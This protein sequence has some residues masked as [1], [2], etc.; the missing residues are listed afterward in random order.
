MTIK[1][2]G[3][4]NVN[5]TDLEASSDFYRRNFGLDVLW[6]TEPPE[7]QDGAL[8]G[9]PGPVRWRGELLCDHRGR[10]GPVLDLLQWIQPATTVRAR[11]DGS[12]GFA[13]LVFSRPDAPADGTVMHDPDGT[14]IA[15]VRGDG[16]QPELAG[17]EIS[18]TSLTE[19][20]T[21]Y[22]DVLGLPVY[23]DGPL[24]TV[25]RATVRR[26]TVRL[27]GAR[28]TFRIILRAAEGAPLDSHRASDVGIHRV[29]IVVTEI[30]A[31]SLPPHSTGAHDVELGSGL[32]R[33]RAAFFT[34]PNGAVLEYV[35]DGLA[36]APAALYPDLHCDISTTNHDRGQFG[37]YLPIS[38]HDH[39]TAQSEGAFLGLALCRSH[40]DGLSP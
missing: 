1:W 35:A 31:A 9:L 12:A 20:V 33:V 36:A 23:A 3:H 27:P 13:R 28:D 38:G 11:P 16:P 5:A 2:F 4:V 26:A 29:A 32:G 6:R 18:C 25:R 24:A 22:R 14:P 8:F 30:E 7:A 10:R 34:D 15:V 19:S 39:E 21:Y 40:S 37:R 17:V